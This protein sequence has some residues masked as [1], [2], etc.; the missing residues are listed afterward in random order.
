ML[1]FDPADTNDKPLPQA[2]AQA[3]YALAVKGGAKLLL[4]ALSEEQIISQLLADVGDAKA[5]PP[6]V[7]TDDDAP[8]T[9][10]G[11]AVQQRL[12]AAI[13]AGAASFQLPDGAIICDVDFEVLGAKDMIIS[14]GKATTFWF[15]PTRAALRVMSAAQRSQLG[16]PADQRSLLGRRPLHRS[17]VGG[18]L[19]LPARRRL[20]PTRPAGRSRDTVLLVAADW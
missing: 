4:G 1:L 9:T 11:A 7:K 20:R 10:P 19:F 6:A 17:R 18:G 14:G 2:E 8:Q 12:N 3:T 15:E 16:A 5:K 13:A